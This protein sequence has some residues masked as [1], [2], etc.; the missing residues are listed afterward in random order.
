M[1]ELELAKKYQIFSCRA[2]SHSYGMNTASSDIDTRGIFIA[3]PEYTV[4]CMKS[5]EQVELPGEDTVIYELGKFLKLASDSNPNI[6]ELLF[7]GEENIL[8]IDPAFEK[9]RAHRHLFLSKKAKY[10]FSGYAMAQMKRIK[11]HHKWIQNPQPERAPE[12]LDFAQFITPQGM[13]VKGIALESNIAYG[14]VFLV[15]LNATTYR[16]FS[17]PHFKKPILSQDRKNI[18]FVDSEASM[19]DAVFLGTLIVQQETY[20]IQHRMWKDYWQ[21][22]KNR[23]EVR[24]ELEEKCGFDCYSDDT[25]FLTELG[26]EKFDDILSGTLLATLNPHTFK[27][28]YQEPVERHEANYSGEMNRFSG[29]HTDINVSANHRMFLNPVKRRSGDKKGWRFTPA[30]MVPETFLIVNRINPVTHVSLPS[31]PKDIYL[32]L[33][34]KIM[35]WYVSEGSVAKRLSSGIPSVLSI[36]QLQGGRLHWRINR[37]IKHFPGQVKINAYSHFRKSKNRTE[38]T[39]TIPDRE[40]A[41]NIVSQCGD[42]S[43][44]K[45]LPRWVMSL[46]KRMK[47]ILLNALHAGDGT[48]SRPH[49]AQVYYTSS[50]QL[51]DDVQE[52]AFLCGFETAKWGLYE[53]DGIGMYQIHINKKAKQFRTFTR[54]NVEK[55]DVW[56][57]RV[58]CFTVP[59]EILITRRNGKIGI[60]GNTKHASHLIRLLRMSHEI[61]RDGKVNVHRSDAI[62]LLAIRNGLFDYDKLIKTA[63][64]MD[65][66]LEGLY[67]TSSL[68]HSSDK[69]AIN[70]L[71]IEVVQEFWKRHQL[72]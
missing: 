1:K 18:Q 70:N 38:M 27:V 31:T 16:I 42:K 69:E 52:L 11:G 30:C 23:N 56:N 25:E 20:R 35:G 71:F 72:V 7:T 24:A 53:N 39:W 62:E 54:K 6:I 57:Q 48:D 60:Q 17:S 37:A 40:L 33:Y 65:A 10:T 26:W 55:K 51:A 13:Q 8:F 12:L 2:G 43:G 5:I 59:N 14:D 63:E 58:V 46:S 19:I 28:E 66:Q 47:E 44:N 64:E 61:L 50:P 41:Q 4:G 34:L 3:P 45:R 15:K 29:H 67:E 49:D 68:P 36:S 32:R 22:K 9:I 21:W